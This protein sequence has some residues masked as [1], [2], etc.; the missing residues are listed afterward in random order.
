MNKTSHR[1]ANCNNAVKGDFCNRC[2]QSIKVSRINLSHLVEELQFSFLHINKG[3][4][5]TI[6]ELLLR[7]GYTIKAYLN[8]KRVQYFKPFGFLLIWGSIYSLVLHFFNVYP[9]SEMNQQDNPIFDNDFIY[10]W[11]YSHY[12]IVQL[13]IIPFYA[14]SSYILYRRS[15]YNYIEH[16]VIYSYIDGIKVIILILLYPL[17]YYTHSKDVY[18]ITLAILYLYNTYVLV[19][20]FKTSS[21]TKA[22]LKAVLS[23]IL[24]LVVA[25]ITIIAILEGIHHFLKVF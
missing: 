17:F 22:I 2:G 1:C 25:S 10:N 4:L 11:Y 13:L 12:S 8:G 16:L 15:N 21:W 20:L 24:T 18:S 6:K 19:Q 7:P 5:Y 3:M 9:D 14:L 23:I